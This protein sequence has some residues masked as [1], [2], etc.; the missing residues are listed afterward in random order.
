MF[1]MTPS[2]LALYVAENYRILV[3]DTFASTVVPKA[4]TIPTV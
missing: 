2:M 1:I 4:N 3:F